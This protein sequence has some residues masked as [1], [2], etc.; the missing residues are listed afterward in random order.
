[1][2]TVELLVALLVLVLEKVLEWARSRLLAPRL[3]ISPRISVLPERQGVRYRAKVTNIRR[4]PL[5]FWPV[6]RIC[7]A[8]ELVLRGLDPDAPSNPIRIPVPL[9]DDGGPR[10]VANDTLVEFPPFDIDLDQHPLL[11]AHVTADDPDRLDLWRLLRLG[12]ASELRLFVTASNTHSPRTVRSY[13]LDDLVLGRFSR[14]P[15]RAGLEIMP[16]GRRRSMAA[17]SWAIRMLPL[18]SH[19]FDD[20]DSRGA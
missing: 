18:P 4:W 6:M 11:A 10:L 3:C 16:R 7:V 8:A 9:R 13:A 15:G 14:E 5:S 2:V 1:M 19:V 17:G 20:L 12:S